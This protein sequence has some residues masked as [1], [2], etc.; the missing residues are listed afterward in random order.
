MNQSR[1]V[2]QL[3]GFR[4]TSCETV[5]AASIAELYARAVGQHRAG[6]LREAEGLYRQVLAIDHKHADSLYNL[7]VLGLQIGRAN[8]GV[9]MIAKAIARND[10]VPE[11]HY[12]LAFGLAALGRDKDAITHYR[13]A[14]TLKPDYAEA[15]MNLGNA[16]KA[17]G[18]LDQAIASYQRVIALQPGAIEAYYNVANV[19]AERGQWGPAAQSYERALALNPNFA[20]ALTN[21][22]IVLSAQGKQAE[23]VAQHQRAIALSPDLVEAYVNL[24]KVLASDGKSEQAATWYRQALARSPEYSLAHNNLGVVLMANGKIDA[25]IASCQRALALQPDLTEALNNLGTMFLAKGQSNRAAECLQ[26]A[27]TLRADFI[28]AYNNLARAYIAE[29][30]VNRA[31]RVLTR[32]LAVRETVE[33]KTLF[34]TCLRS[35]RSVSDAEEYRDAV[36]RA[37]S[38]PWGRPGDLAQFAAH[39]VVQNPAIGASIALT[40]DAWPERLLP[41]AWLSSTTREVIARD[42]LL[43]A[44]LENG[45]IVDVGL[46]RFLTALRLAL[47]GIAADATEAD[48]ADPDELRLFCALARQCFVNDYVFEETECETAQAERLRQRLIAALEANARVPVLW[49]VAV[50]AYFP[51]HSLPA[52]A[53]LVRRPWPEAVAS[54]LQQQVT[55]P[56]AER[57]SAD[58]IARLTAIED[59]VS[60]RV[61]QQYEQNPYPRW[62]KSAPPPDP[63]TIDEYLRRQFPLSAFHPLGKSRDVEV[64]IAG[65]GTGQHSIEVAQR[66]RGVRLLAVDLSLKS[67]CYAKRQTIAL[68]VDNIEY[69]QAD[70]LGLGGLGRTFDVIEAAGVVHHLADPRAGWRALSSV[71]R[72]GGMLFLGLYSEI[73]RRDIVTARAFIAERGY[74]P[75][76]EDIRRC[77]QQLMDADDGTALKR[78]T[79]TAD[80]G[81]TSECRDLLFHAQEHRTTLPEVKAA[82]AANQLTFLGFEIDSWVRRQYA[83]R[84]PDD[85]AMTNLDNWR[86]FEIEN[87]LTFVRMYQ[88]W[89]QKA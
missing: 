67:L 60:L 16:L 5:A 42:R 62:V 54:L 75:T 35:L 89:A 4:R 22:G 77:R 8:F 20:Q 30:D 85:S 41:A 38:E 11:W 65:C 18:Q 45:R 74:G 59:D 26:R 12:N 88:F 72:P 68:G 78:V 71:L 28:E 66:W 13:R 23:A 9:E 76:V 14:V 19:F 57:L 83:A 84:H 73:A 69:A 2:D 17:A 25:A 56:E 15:H 36:V 1:P 48:S 29:R 61:Q 52:V 53:A 64:L 55:E 63:A 79:Q 7:G 82:L 81:S 80:F 87:P 37:L 21:Y 6:F 86:D 39:L 44:L 46:E 33:T 3:A 31:L 49:P 70:I 47:L 40:L 50:A 27:I 10:R 32:A 51:L 34:V 58:S 24:G 43:Q